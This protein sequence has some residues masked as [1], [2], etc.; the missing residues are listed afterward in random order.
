MCVRRS[1]YISHPL[2]KEGVIERREYQISIAEVAKKSSTMVVLP[3]GLGKTTVALLVILELLE[4]C[5]SE[6]MLQQQ[7]AQHLGQRDETDGRSGGGCDHARERFDKILFLAPTRPLVEQHASFLRNVLKMEH[8]YVM[9][10][11]IPA[12]K[13]VDLWRNG[14]IVIST[15]QV[16]ENDILAARISLEDVSLLIFDECHRA[17]GNYSYVFIAEKYR[18]QRTKRGKKPLILGL[19]ASPGSEKERIIEICDALGIEV[20]ESRTE[21]D[22]DVAPYVHEKRVEWIE[23]EVPSEIKK[24]KHILEELLAER[25]NELAKLGF[26]CG[27]TKMELL[28]LGEDLKE[29]LASGDQDLY[30][31]L[32]LQAEALKIRH[33]I[34]LLGSEGVF[35]LR[36]YIE[37][38]NNEASS[39][40]GSKA[41]RR[42]FKDEKFVSAIVTI[43]NYKGE[44]PKLKTLINVVKDEIRRNP[45]T[46]IIIFAEFRDT[47]DMIMDA[48][49]SLNLEKEGIKA[50]KFIG[51]SARGDEKGLKQREQVEIIEL[52]K[53]GVYN[54][55]VA[56]SVAEEGLDIPSTDLVIFYE[57]IPSAIRSIQRKGRT[58][59]MRFGRVVVLI[60]KGT[61]DEAYYWRSMRKEREMRRMISELKEIGRILRNTH[62]TADNS[63]TSSAAASSAT[64]NAEY[65][66]VG[67]V[68]EGKDE[69]EQEQEQEKERER[70]GQR[71]LSD[72][73]RLTVIVDHRESRSSVAGFL[74]RAGVNVRFEQLEVGDY[75]I[76]ERLCV[77]RKTVRDFFDSLLS[78]RRDLLRQ[79][80]QLRSTYE[81]A[82]LVLEGDEPLYGMRDV[83]PNVIRGVLAA[84]AVDFSVPILQTRD[85]IDT[86]S[87]I[88]MLARREQEERRKAV[89]ALRK[90]P[91]SDA[92]LREQQEFIVTSLPNVGI[93][94]ARKLLKHFKSVERIFNA[95]AEELLRVEGI[96]KAKAERIRLILSSEYQTS[97]S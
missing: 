54:T 33:A 88:Y 62:G 94:T 6:E 56:T 69:Q 61:K 28:E 26:R 4:N 9:T 37:R 90:K 8:I 80:Q 92:S 51:Q 82:L 45:D 40:K 39:K 15:P 32:S 72:F 71:R 19:T 79:V 22:A 77:E 47:V 30:H 52:F 95:S 74:R 21:N 25:V 1:Q 16:I 34:D 42:L 57:P 65:V 59:R 86:A 46:R 35:A 85:E 53:K 2:L 67:N 20:I 10:G 55:L 78:D 70:A 5:E 11:A 81:K 83:S 64:L 84:I 60:A 68:K 76:S 91:S 44:H 96:G 89:R 17:V 66:H 50:V 43:L 31:A 58:G 63:T 23:I 3:T 13:R 14:R 24:Q 18:E 41:A 87:L 75:V 48:F 49:K 93:Q 73:F 36:K 12:K 27:S 38:L 97:D 29:R 7:Q